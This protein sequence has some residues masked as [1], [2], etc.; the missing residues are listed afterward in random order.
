MPGTPPRP[1]LPT[2]VFL[3]MRS[4]DRALR[5]SPGAPARTSGRSAPAARPRPPAPMEHPACRDRRLGDRRGNIPVGHPSRAHR[6]TAS[7]PA[8]IPPVRGSPPRSWVAFERGLR[9]VPWS[10]TLR[11]PGVTRQHRAG[12]SGREGTPRR[13]WRTRLRPTAPTGEAFRQRR[14]GRRHRYRGRA[15]GVP[16][17]AGTVRLRQ[18]HHAADARRLRAARP[19]ATSSS[20]ASRSRASPR[21]SATSTPCSSTTRC[22]RT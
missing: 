22:S 8:R 16:V 2:R 4:S 5:P 10:G 9:H 17:A 21:T 20:R 15:R 11:P 3:R 14:R 18:D 6:P 1:G 12:R 13:E 7:R 19:R